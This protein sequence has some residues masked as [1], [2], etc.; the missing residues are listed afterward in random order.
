MWLRLLRSARSSVQE[1]LVG[2]PSEDRSLVCSEWHRGKLLAC[3][4]GI[5]S[6]VSICNRLNPFSAKRL[7]EF[8]SGSNMLNTQVEIY[9]LDPLADW[10]YA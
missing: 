4:I 7:R 8:V 5:N 9:E 1:A 6:D 10:F 2:H 3:D